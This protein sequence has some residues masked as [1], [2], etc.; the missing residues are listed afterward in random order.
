L[1]IALIAWLEAFCS[2]SP[3]GSSVQFDPA[4]RVTASLS[5]DCKGSLFD[6]TCESLCRVCLLLVVESLTHLEDW[7]WSAH[8]PTLTSNACATALCETTTLLAEAA[9]IPICKAR[10]TSFP[11]HF[12]SRYYTQTKDAVG[13][14]WSLQT[15]ESIYREAQYLRW[16]ALLPWSL[17]TIHEIPLYV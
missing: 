8:N 11:L 5:R 6:L 17:L 3:H 9:S 7:T 10:A 1:G 14:Q 16:D 4:P 13:M 15:K 12:L 2:A